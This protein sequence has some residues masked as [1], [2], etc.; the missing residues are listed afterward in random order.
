M[1]PS[2]LLKTV[3]SIVTLPTAKQPPRVHFFNGLY[4]RQLVKRA[5]ALQA[6]LDSQCHEIAIN[7]GVDDIFVM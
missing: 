7:D 2:Q 1:R 4:S 6:V 5:Q 3:M